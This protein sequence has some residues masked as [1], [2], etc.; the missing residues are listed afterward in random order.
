MVQFPLVPLTDKEIIVFFFN[1]VSRPIVATRIYGRQWGPAE[2]TDVINEHR[3]VRPD[4][5][6]RNTCSV[7]FTTAL[8]L[9]R[10]QAKEDPGDW[11]M[12]ARMFFNQEYDDAIATDAIRL[13]GDEAKLAVDFNVQDL[14]QD[15]IKFPYERDGRYALFTQCIMY[16]KQEGINMKLSQLHVLAIAIHNQFHP[17]TIFGERKDLLDEDGPELA[18]ED[19][20]HLSTT[21][22]S[23]SPSLTTKV[24]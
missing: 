14:L 19:E 2:V 6:K 24:A 22:N 13:V 12:K 5:Y 16:C 17:S 7:K 18:I 9:G 3:I 23:N 8:N 10:K 15:L 4:G 11:E 20:F 21:L 1:S